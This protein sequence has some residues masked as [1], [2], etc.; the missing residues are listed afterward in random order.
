MSEQKPDRG[1]L[2]Y[3][4]IGCASCLL[5]LAGLA[6]GCG[7]LA[8]RY[9][10][11]LPNLKPYRT[12]RP[13]VTMPV[14]GTPVR[15]VLDVGS[16]SFRIAPAAPGQPLAVEADFDQKRFVLEE[17]WSGNPEL[18][19]TYTLRYSRRG[20]LPRIV[21][22]GNESELRLLL[23]RD[24]PLTIVGDVGVG[25]SELELGG[26]NLVDVDIDF[27]IGDH[28]LSFSEPLA[29]PMRE[30]V[31]N[32][33]IGELTVSGLGHAS[34]EQVE[35]GHSLGELDVDLSG[36]WQRDTQ[37]EINGGIGE[38]H[39]HVPQEVGLDLGRVRVR[40]GEQSVPESKP[41]VDGRPIVHLSAS[42]TMGELSIDHR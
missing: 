9:S 24:V 39:I 30:L 25:E 4:C 16:T 37:V 36:R 31:L 11:Q 3:G 34:P 15:V 5:L 41:V 7:I 22:R 1:C 23:P 33:G 28:A 29:A 32:G 12:E 35:I 6:A 20:F 18:A 8:W 14:T 38:C 42:S 21:N 27:G 13:L 26:L 17:I 10:Q 2:R 19:R 40:V